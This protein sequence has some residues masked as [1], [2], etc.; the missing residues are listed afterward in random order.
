MGTRDAL[1]TLRTSSLGVVPPPPPPSAARLAFAAPGNNT[2]AM[3]AKLQASKAGAAD[4][5]AKMRALKG[6][7]RGQKVRSTKQTHQRDWRPRRTNGK[8]AN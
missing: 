3:R 8:S 6:A 1:R 7:A 5:E 2:A 4:L